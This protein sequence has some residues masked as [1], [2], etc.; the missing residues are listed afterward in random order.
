MRAGCPATNLIVAVALAGSLVGFNHGGLGRAVGVGL[1]AIFAT[2]YFLWS[3][4]NPQAFDFR[5]FS[6]EN[7]VTYYFCNDEYAAEFDR[8][9]S[10]LK[11][12]RHLT[13]G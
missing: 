13:T 8:L 5:L 4:L 11:S 1:A 7:R 6:N 2:P 10:E 12:S 3:Y 9:N